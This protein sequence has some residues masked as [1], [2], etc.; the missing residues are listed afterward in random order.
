MTVQRSGKKAWKVI[1]FAS[2]GRPRWYHI[3]DVDAVGLADARK[4]ASRVMFAVA[5]GKDPV[6]VW[7]KPAQ[8][9]AP[10]GSI[11]FGVSLMA[12]PI[13]DTQYKN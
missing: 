13:T 2:G 9:V 12:L 6:A 4:L 10:E 8:P 5:E 3:G 11:R 1:Y 7:V